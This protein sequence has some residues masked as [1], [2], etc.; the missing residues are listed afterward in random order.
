MERESQEDE[1]G[2]LQEVVWYDFCYKMN[3][4]AVVLRI[5]CGGR[6]PGQNQSCQPGGYCNGLR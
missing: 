2:K 3:P 4:L 1:V 5:C 6:R